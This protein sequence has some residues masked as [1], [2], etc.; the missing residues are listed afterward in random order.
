[1]RIDVKDHQ[2]LMSI[3]RTLTWVAQ[4]GPEGK[5]FF[6]FNSIPYYYIGG[7]NIRVHTFVTEYSLFSVLKDPGNRREK[8]KTI[9]SK[10]TGR[11]AKYISHLLPFLWRELG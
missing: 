1:M 9:V 8:G 4:R 5:E 10:S 3:Q 11:K 7:K 2:R 6:F